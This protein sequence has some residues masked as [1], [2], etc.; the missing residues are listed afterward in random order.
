MSTTTI[1]AKITKNRGRGW[2]CATYIKYPDWPN[3]A[4]TH[5]GYRTLKSTL[6]HLVLHCMDLGAELTTV[7]VKGS[8]MPKAVI[9]ERVCQA[10]A[11]GVLSYKLPAV[12]EYLSQEVT[13][14]DG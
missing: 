2:S 8:L 1:R 3:E 10:L 7:H 12:R 9:L 6:W 5:T 11:G 4:V 14:E 13:N